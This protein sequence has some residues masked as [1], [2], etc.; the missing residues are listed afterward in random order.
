VAKPHD[1]IEAGGGALFQS[2]PFYS[3]TELLRELLGVARARVAEEQLTQLESALNLAGLKPAEALPLIALLLSLPL[4]SKYP[5]V[6]AF[7]RAAAHLNTA[8]L[9]EIGSVAASRGVRAVAS[10]SNSL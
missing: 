8:T 3:V 4:P 2:T 7:I 10:D 1:W 6:T 5:A 9:C